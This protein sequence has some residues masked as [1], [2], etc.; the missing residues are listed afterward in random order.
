MYFNLLLLFSSETLILI[1][2]TN[3]H[4]MLEV[5]CV[6]YSR[7]YHDRDDVRSE[8]LKLQSQEPGADWSMGKCLPLSGTHLVSQARQLADAWGY[9][10]SLVWFRNGFSKI[11]NVWNEENQDYARR[12]IYLTVSHHLEIL[13]FWVISILWILFKWKSGAE[14]HTHGCLLKDDPWGL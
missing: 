1:L 2:W 14:S 10:G 8:W 7:Q 9:F 13:T 4:P 6:Q 11:W 3:Y 12:I 5:I